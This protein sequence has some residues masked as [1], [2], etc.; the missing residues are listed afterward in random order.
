MEI[1]SIFT[2]I[3]I[4]NMVY[5]YNALKLTYKTLPAVITPDS[6]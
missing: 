6:R 5:V 2:L 4:K 1:E 3:S